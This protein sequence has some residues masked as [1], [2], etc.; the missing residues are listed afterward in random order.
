[1]SVTDSCGACYIGSR[2]SFF[3]WLLPA[4][5]VVVLTAFPPRC[6]PIAGGYHPVQVGELFNSGRYAVMHFLGQGH[7]STV[8]MVR[9]TETGQQAAMKVRAAG[10]RQGPCMHSGTCFSSLCWVLSR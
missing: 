7:Y 6:F 8:W 5:A 9:D 4:V 2:P 1:M 3:D 10:W